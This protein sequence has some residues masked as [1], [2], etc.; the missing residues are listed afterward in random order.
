MDTDRCERTLRA[1]ASAVRSVSVPIPK[2]NSR[3]ST[4]SPLRCIARQTVHLA[5]HHRLLAC[6]RYI[7]RCIISFRA[8]SCV[9]RILIYC[10]DRIARHQR[11]YLPE[12]VGRKRSVRI[13]EQVLVRL[14]V[15]R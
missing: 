5:A 4:V 8:N 6:A 12:R 10:A 7:A 9:R 1:L 14:A 2:S 13:G 11:V 3:Q 15:G